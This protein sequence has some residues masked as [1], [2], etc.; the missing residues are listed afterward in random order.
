[1]RDP[2]KT[3][4]GMADKAKLAY[5]SYLDAEGFPTTR[6]MLAP[7]EREGIRVFWF[8]TNTS[9]RKVAAFRENPKGSVYFVD[10]RFFRGVSLSGTVEVLEDPESKRRLWQV[11]D[12][13]YYP[14][15]VT[16][17]DYC[18]LKFTAEKGRYYSNF[19]SEDFA[20]PD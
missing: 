12:V 6:A 15:G 9:S 16:D 3:V 20:I 11:G 2:E 8:S 14:Q 4:G 1:M 5:L 18:V 19:K 17:P 13:M 10:R 7:R